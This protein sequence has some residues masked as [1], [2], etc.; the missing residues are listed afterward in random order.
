MSKTALIT[1]IAGQDGSYLA[2]LLVKKDY[3]VHGISRYNG[4]SLDKFVNLPIYKEYQKNIHIH[5]A[6]MEDTSRI[7]R[8]IHDTRPSEIYHLA[9]QS[10]VG[11]SFNIPVST[12]EISAMGT[13]RLLEIIK[14][15][16]GDK[17]KF[18]HT[19][20]SEIFGQPKT[21]PQNELTCHN[22]ITPYGI[23]KSFA[24]NMVKLYRETEGLFAVNAI[25]YNHESP[26]RSEE[27]VTRKIIK[28]AVQ[29]KRAQV[30]HL[31]LGDLYAQRDW[32]YAPDYVEAM[33][34][35]LQHNTP[36]DFIVAT[37][38][39]HTVKDWL[40]KTFELLGLDV[41]RHVRFDASLVRPNRVTG[42]VGDNKK[43]LNEL[44]WRPKHDFNS[45]IVEMIKAELKS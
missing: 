7:E 3:I 22:P 16:N 28:T 1:G 39:T 20:S 15:L 9:S 42:L 17:P 13:L 40:E 31:E 29:I 33:W 11:H 12:C 43:I 45:I 26:R 19:S 30:S 8:I 37:G 27:Y 18:L 6:S 24:T 4:G 5:Y 21:A 2:E 44:K 34:L 35:I 10:H 41:E 32:G 38:V 25:C 14:N 36:Q 23:A